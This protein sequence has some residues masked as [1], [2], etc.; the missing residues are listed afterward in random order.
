MALGHRR[1][2]RVPQRPGHRGHR[3]SRAR[4]HAGDH[5][6]PAERRLPRP[7]GDALHVRRANR[8]LAYAG[9]DRRPDP[10]CGALLHLGK[11]A[12]R[13]RTCSQEPELPRPATGAVRRHR[14]PDAAERRHVLQRDSRGRPRPRLRADRPGAERDRHVRAREP[15]RGA[16]PPAMVLR[17]GAMHL[18]HPD[19]HRASALLRPEHAQSRQLRDRP[20]DARRATRP[21]EWTADRQV[22]AT[23]HAGLPQ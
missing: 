19:E 21:W 16:G 10:F 6:D 7:P 3:H 23:R 15:R 1:R 12:E 18:L 4:R 14:L 5:A 8:L 11:P 13:P 22:L 9:G 20:H 17:P 2:D